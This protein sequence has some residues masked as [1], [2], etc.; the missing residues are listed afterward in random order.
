[1]LR[2]PELKRILPDFPFNTTLLWGTSLSL[3]INSWILRT[4]RAI[5]ANR[6]Y[7]DGLRDPATRDLGEVDFATYAVLADVAHVVSIIILT[8]E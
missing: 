6:N 8:T 3:R 5:S 1:M 4:A 7:I 2:I